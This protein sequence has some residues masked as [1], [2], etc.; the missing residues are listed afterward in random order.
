MVLLAGANAS[1]LVNADG[2]SVVPLIL[3][4][5]RR[6]RNLAPLLLGHTLQELFNYITRFDPDLSGTA[7]CC[8]F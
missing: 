7:V 2:T 6:R 1:S 3:L 5:R 4:L 8:W